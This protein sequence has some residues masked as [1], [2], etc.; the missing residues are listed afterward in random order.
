M[1]DEQLKQGELAVAMLAGG[2]LLLA[3]R[4]VW[5]LTKLAFGLALLAAGIAV[6][7]FLAFVAVDGGLGVFN[8]GETFF[9][10]GGGTVAAIVA[11]RTIRSE[12]EFAAR[13][14]RIENEGMP[15]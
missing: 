10:I 9:L 1:T 15:E 11:W 4:I 7:G 6:F 8:P 5:G 12:K 3:W 13:L 2:A 14:K